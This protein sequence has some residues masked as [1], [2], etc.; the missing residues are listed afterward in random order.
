L[1]PDIALGCWDVC[2]FYSLD[3]FCILV[4]ASNKSL[5]TEDTTGN[6]GILDQ[7]AALRWVQKHI[8]RFCGDPTKVVLF[9]QSAGAMSVAAHLISHNSHEYFHAAILSSPT[10]HSSYFFQSKEDSFAFS[11]WAAKTLAGCEGGHDLDCLRKVPVS[12]FNIEEHHRDMNSPPHASRL[13]PYMPWGLT[14]DG[15]VIKG[16]PLEI[17]RLGKAAKIPVILGVT[18]D[19]GSSF[20]LILNRL[21]RPRIYGDI[22]AGV[23]EGMVDHLLGD[24]ALT[25]KLLKDFNSSWVPQAADESKPVPT[26]EQVKEIKDKLLAEFT[27]IGER[28]ISEMTL[29]EFKAAIPTLDQIA[30]EDKP[31]AAFDKNPFSFFVKTLRDSIFACPSIDFAQALSQHNPGDVWLYNFGLE[32]W[33][34]TP[35]TTTRL[36]DGGISGAGNLTFADLGAYHGAEIP[37]IFNLFP[38]KTVM[39]ADLSNSGNSH[40]AFTHTNFCPIDSFK[41]DVAD[42]IGC[43]WTNMGK[44]GKPQ[45]ENNNCGVAEEWEPWKQLSHHMDIHSRGEFTMR[46]THEKAFPS[47]MEC[48]KWHDRRVPFH[49]FL[50]QAENKTQP[51]SSMYAETAKGLRS[52]SLTGILVLLVSVLVAI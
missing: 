50:Q 29:E 30:R 7:R 51:L 42:K 15:S 13:F 38:N 39:P 36:A 43:M 45:C 19:E 8:R 16:T 46:L 41:R 32:V 22:P 9:G 14:I 24:P 52:A 47:P 5:D 26:E 28:D 37:F 20:A 44:C 11:D 49:N 34:D 23:M 35:W 12:R 31:P 33:A 48:R 3:R 21:V 10:V 18:E 1:F 4:F 6:W 25:A 17:A 27:A 40:M 2:E